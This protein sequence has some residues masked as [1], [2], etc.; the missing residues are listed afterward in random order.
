MLSGL[1]SAL[2]CVLWLQAL[3][4]DMASWRK[5]AVLLTESKEKLNNHVLESTGTKMA[6]KTSVAITLIECNASLCFSIQDSNFW[7]EILIILVL[8]SDYPRSCTHIDIT[9]W[10]SMPDIS[11]ELHGEI[12]KQ[13]LKKWDAWPKQSSTSYI[14]I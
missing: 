6:S 10:G 9:G 12:Q 1:Y 8:S 11:L 4:N 3:N 2:L 14:P 7:K 5:N 13:G